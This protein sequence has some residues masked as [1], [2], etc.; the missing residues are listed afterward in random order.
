MRRQL[1]EAQGDS[2]CQGHA[3]VGVVFRT[4]PC[5]CPRPQPSAAA[6]RLCVC[7]R[8]PS[9]PRRRD[10]LAKVG[11]KGAQLPAADDS[12]ARAQAV[13]LEQVRHSLPWV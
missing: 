6:E 7:C 4:M 5:S 3:V 9:V 2:C 13:A 10:M 8:C 1:P 11:F 12:P